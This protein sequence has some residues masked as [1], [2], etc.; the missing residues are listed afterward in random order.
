VLWRADGSAFAAV[1]PGALLV[2]RGA[3]LTALA[4][5]TGK[6]LWTRPLPG[7]LP[8]GAVALAR[9]PFALVEPGVVTGLDP[10]SGRTLWR[11]EPPG[12][13][14]LHAGAFG[15]IVAVGADTGFLYGVDAAGRVAW[16]LRA[17]GPFD[18]PPAPVGQACLA[19]AAADPGAVLLAVDPATG[20]RRWEAPI[21]FLPAGPP[22]AWGRHVVV[23]G[24]IAGDPAVSALDAGGAP[25]WTSSP[26][27]L[28]GVPALA[29]GGAFLVVRDPRGAVVALGRDAGVRWSRAARA[30]HPPPGA[31]APAIARGTVILPAGEGLAALDV[32]SGEIV[33]AIPG[34]SP[35]RL[36]VDAALG[37]AAMDADGLA[38]GW[39]M[40]T[41]FSVV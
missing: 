27:L 15:G 8:T 32:R 40:A 31:A 12:A 20:T 18:R 29:V 39:R 16:R 19:I 26:P 37:V 9:G 11:F 7:A 1:V 13:A 30:E 2:T 38:S 5:R 35:S 34:V 14:R 41:H 24:A 28:A 22:L 17:R 6:T 10:G 36:L 4:P 23:A 3:A 21:D 25:S 33:G